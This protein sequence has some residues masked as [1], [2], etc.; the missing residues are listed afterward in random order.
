MEDI[1]KNDIFGTSGKYEMDIWTS[2]HVVMANHIC[3]LGLWQNPK[4][5]IKI[6]RLM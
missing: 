3:G 5:C 4:L 1:V 2:N 6:D